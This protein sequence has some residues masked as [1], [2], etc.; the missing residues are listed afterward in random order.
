MGKMREEIEKIQREKFAES[1]R[2]EKEQDKAAR[3]S[4]LRKIEQDKAERRAK[5]LGGSVP[6]AAAASTGSTA[7]VES[8][9][10][11][12]DGK[13]KLAVRLLDGSS[14]MQEFDSKEILSSVRAY[15]V[16]QKNITCNISLAMPPKPAFTEEDMEKP[17]YI[18][19]LVP[20]ARLQVVKRS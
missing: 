5:T 19:G 7:P 13:T 4:I 8:S 14:I 10:V 9:N 20:N 3:D 2:R 18:L 17:L 11:S 15:I 16:T 12:K 6:T 1:I